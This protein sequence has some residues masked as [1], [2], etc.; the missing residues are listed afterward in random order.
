MSSNNTSETSREAGPEP[1]VIIYDGDCPF[2]SS[3]V[4]LVRLRESIGEVTLINARDGGD[5]VEKVKALGFDL[6]EGMVLKYEGK[7][8]HGAA[9]VRMIALLSDRTFFNRIC[10][11][12]YRSEKMADRVYPV[13]RAGRNATL[14]LL[15]RR[16]L[17]AD[18][19]QH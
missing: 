16:K 5:E 12:L 18:Q 8:Y 9:C 6:D 2:C 17:S 1:T 19:A 11:A 7:Y 10:L 13:L 3:Y 4:G 14:R 15:G